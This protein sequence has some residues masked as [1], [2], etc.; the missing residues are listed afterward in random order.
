MTEKHLSKKRGVKARLGPPVLF[1]ITA[2]VVLFLLFVN[3]ASA[4]MIASPPDEQVRLTEEHIF[5]VFDPLTASQTVVVHHVFAPTSVSF[6][7]L[8]P[9]PG[10]ARTTTLRERTRRA[11]DRR[12]HPVGRPRRVLDVEFRSWLKGCV[13][14][15][16][17]LPDL[18]MQTENKE[19][20]LGSQPY[21]S[22]GPGSE[23]LHGWLTENGLTLTPEQTRRLDRLR[24]MGWQLVAVRIDAQPT[25]RLREK[26]KGP[27]LALTHAAEE[28]VVAPMWRSSLDISRHLFE[29]TFLSEW[30]P[31]IRNAPDY[32]PFLS[33]NSSVND[34]KALSRKPRSA[35]WSFRR[36]GMIT[37]FK[38]PPLSAEGL[39][40][41]D[42]VDPRPDVKPPMRI[43]R[44]PSSVVLP[45]EVVFGLPAGL[46]WLWIRRRRRERLFG[47]V[48]ER[49]R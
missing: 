15:E 47:R 4:T 26:L 14:R 7:L 10:P 13:A 45:L 36:S 42:P 6:G 49:L 9:V 43:S 30:S 44:K 11:L 41:L 31:A 8:I 20:T 18:E 28:A 33:A 16:V 21:R 3:Q 5:V 38:N 24:A 22:L 23:A 34:L 17:G 35:P 39:I 25:D 27:I 46:W 37:A 19:G 40:H 48:G 32:E 1:L 2:P 29:L 12:L